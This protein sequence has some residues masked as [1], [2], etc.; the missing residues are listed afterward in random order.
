M[1]VDSITRSLKP[2][3]D[4][5]HTGCLVFDRIYSQVPEYVARELGV[6]RQVQGHDVGQASVMVRHIAGLRCWLVTKSYQRCL[7]FARLCKITW[8]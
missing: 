5:R 3:D 6:R 4:T 7:L 1:V 2:V 8:L